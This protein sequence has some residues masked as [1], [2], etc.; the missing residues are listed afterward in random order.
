MHT[1]MEFL[2]ESSTQYITSETEVSEG[3]TNGSEH[4]LEIPILG[5]PG[6]TSR[7]DAVF[8]GESLL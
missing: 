2:F 1:D 8:S 6:A 7:D 5:N 4:F 3:Q